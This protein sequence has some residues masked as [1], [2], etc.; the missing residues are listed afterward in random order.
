MFYLWS[1]PTQQWC[2]KRKPYERINA[3]LRQT[4]NC[5]CSAI[6]LNLLVVFFSWKTHTKNIFPKWCYT[7][8]K[9]PSPMVMDTL[10]VSKNRK[11]EQSIKEKLP[12][13]N[14]TNWPNSQL[15]NLIDEQPE[16]ISNLFFFLDNI[17]A[18]VCFGCRVH[19]Y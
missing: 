19:I 14:Y 6:H 7:K 2:I 16:L 9:T 1:V 8:T 13:V 3:F 11:K 10:T 18:M 12:P 5:F 4:N 17:N 15:N